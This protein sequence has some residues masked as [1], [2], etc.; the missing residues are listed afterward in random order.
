M[1]DYTLKSWNDLTSLKKR[2]AEDKTS[3]SVV[4][5]TGYSL[6]TNHFVYTLYDGILTRVKK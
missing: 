2:I 6:T 4:E 3:E 5:F 1:T